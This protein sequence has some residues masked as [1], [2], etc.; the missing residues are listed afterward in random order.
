MKTKRL[1]FNYRSLTLS[2]YMEL[3][4]SIPNK[5]TYDAASGEYAPDY[6]LEG[7]HL[8]LQPHVTVDEETGAQGGEV[9]SALANIKWTETTTAASTEINSA[10]KN[11]EITIDGPQNGRIA[12]KRN[13]PAGSS[14]T[15][16]FEAD[17]LDTRKNETHHVVMSYRVTCENEVTV[18]MLSIDRPVT[19][20]WNPF[21]DT[22]SMT[23]NASL[24]VGTE[25]VA[26]A[27]RTFVWEKKRADGTW[28]QIGTDQHDDFGWSVTNNGA[29]YTQDMDFIGEKQD[30]RVRAAYGSVALATVNESLTQYFTMV[31]RLPDYD[32]DYINVPDNI[33]PDVKYVYPAPL[34]QDRE[35]VVSNPQ[36]HLAFN[37]YT[38]AGQAAGNPTMALEAVGPSPQIPTSKINKNGMVLGI[39]A[40]DR[41]NYKK[42]TQG[43][44]LITQV[45]NGVECAVIYK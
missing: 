33:E 18:P 38:A 23:F 42:V 34:V 15:L 37:W 19:N 16:T 40:T 35:G 14:I 2:R 36:E 11:Y 26:V 32:Y 12:V 44:N 21:R 30:M 28:S 13:V 39:E 45:I 24:K 4:G 25:E 10:N 31:R 5:Q 6:T 27:Q 1:D 22:H 29:T 7:S 20:L 17:Y 41:G 3:V 9:T 43:S 8:V